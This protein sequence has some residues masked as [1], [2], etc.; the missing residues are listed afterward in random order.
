MSDEGLKSPIKSAVLRIQRALLKFS[1]REEFTCPICGYRGPFLDIR[2][3]SGLRKNAKCPQ[4]GLFE[5]HRLQR[6][7]LDLIAKRH[8]FSAMRILHFAPESHLRTYF[9]QVFR[10]YTSADLFM[11]DVDFHV[12]LQSLPF[13]DASYDLVYA[14]HVLEHVKDDRAAL[15]EIRRVL[16]PTGIAVLPVPIVEEQTIEYPAANAAEHGHV[17]APGVDYYDRYNRF[18][19]RVEKYSS[20]DFP[21]VYQTYIYERRDMYPTKDMPWRKPMAGEKHKDTVPVCF[22]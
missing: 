1:S 17:R 3:K 8:D 21:P 6:L 16:S 20:E 19:T 12:D 22:A 15:K 4:C 2:P 10:E 5:R 9:R 13:P 7:V 14:S 11:K 18:F